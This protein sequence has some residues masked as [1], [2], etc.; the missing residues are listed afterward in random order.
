MNRHTRNPG[1]VQ[2]M[3]AHN[4]AGP[5]RGISVGLLVSSVV[6]LCLIALLM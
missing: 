2:S 1:R 3:D 6:W 4:L 5:G